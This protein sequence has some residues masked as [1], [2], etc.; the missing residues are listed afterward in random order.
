LTERASE[1][2]NEK[3]PRGNGMADTVMLGN[4]ERESTSTSVLI[5]RT[6]MP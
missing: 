2:D 4:I 3:S 5:V 6:D 1:Y